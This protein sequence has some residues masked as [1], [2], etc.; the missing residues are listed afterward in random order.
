MNRQVHSLR[1]LQRQVLRK[2]RLEALEAELARRKE[3]LELRAQELQKQQV[4]DI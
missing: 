4:Y 3:E 2:K 1:E